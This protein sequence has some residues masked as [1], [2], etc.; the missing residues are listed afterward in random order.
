VA[1]RILPWLTP[2]AAGDP[3]LIMV[4]AIPFHISRGETNVIGVHIVV[5][6]LA[7][8]VARGRFRRVPIASR[9]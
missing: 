6:G 3:A 1:T 8:F 2:V 5:S 7:L 4:L 9:S